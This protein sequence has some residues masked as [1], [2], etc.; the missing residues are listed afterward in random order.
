ML[1]SDKTNKIL[2]DSISIDHSSSS[3]LPWGKY[4]FEVKLFTRLMLEVWSLLFFSYLIFNN[5]L[6][7]RC[8]KRLKV[9]K[10]ND[11]THQ[12]FTNY[13]SIHS[14][15][16]WFQVLWRSKVPRSAYLIISS[17][18]NKIFTW[19][20]ELFVMF[21]DFVIWVITIRDGFRIWSCEFQ[22]RLIGQ[23]QHNL[24]NWR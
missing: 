3:S 14:K 11:K 8:I 23:I 21:H 12:Y 13:S 6:A 4:C 7:F 18:V 22:F 15:S 19:C 10:E 24:H 16:I 2:V 1:I 5:I 20:F 17:I 9:N